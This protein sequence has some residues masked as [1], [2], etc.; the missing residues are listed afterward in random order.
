MPHGQCRRSN[1]ECRLFA[2]AG[3][4][5]EIMAGIHSEIATVRKDLVDLRA[6]R[7]RLKRS[8]ELDDEA[9]RKKLGELKADIENVT[10][11]QS[12]RDAAQAEYDG[13]LQAASRGG[14]IA[15]SATRAAERV[16]KAIKRLIQGL[17]GAELRPGQPNHVLRDF[18]LH[19]ERYLWVPSVGVAGGKRRKGAVVGRGGSLTKGRLG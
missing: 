6:A 13:L 5:R 3:E 10:L 2:G 11:P 17:K 8:D 14:K 7:E 4:V 9:L 12:E 1:R 15:D 16:R 19:L 18:G